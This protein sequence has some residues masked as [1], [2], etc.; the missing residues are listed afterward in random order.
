MN[1][2]LQESLSGLALIQILV[3]EKKRSDDFTKVNHQAFQAGMK[4]VQVF[5]LF[6]PLMELISAM[7][8]ALLI[9]YGGGRVIQKTLSLGSLVAFLSYIQMFFKPLREMTE[10]YSVMQSAM[11]SLERIFSLMDE[12]AEEEPSIPRP[13][14]Y[15]PG[16]GKS[17]SAKSALPM[18]RTTG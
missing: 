18:I 1:A 5:A 15:L 13:D 11:A 2:F 3:R 16:K 17:N 12:K 9:W 7:A 10:K 4:Q 6:M 14:L 8:I